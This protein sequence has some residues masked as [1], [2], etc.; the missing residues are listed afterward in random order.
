MIESDIELHVYQ[1]S[2]S[3]LPTCSGSSKQ[4]EAVFERSGF[5][6]LEDSCSYKTSYSVSLV[7]SGTLAYGVAASSTH[8][9]WCGHPS[10][11]YVV[12]R[13]WPSPMVQSEVNGDSHLVVGDAKGHNIHIPGRLRWN[14]GSY[15]GYPGHENCGTTIALVTDRN[16]I[17]AERPKISTYLVRYVAGAVST[18][19]L[20]LPLAI[21]AE[22]CRIMVDDYKGTVY[23]LDT[24]G[25]LYCIPYA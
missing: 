7:H 4:T 21:V 20:K 11:D 18:H 14:G 9:H 17:G 1:C 23:L 3:I 10:G 5:Y 22:G 25:M 12:I 24:Y 2:C 15:V 8:Q 13:F 19:E 16:S 6:L